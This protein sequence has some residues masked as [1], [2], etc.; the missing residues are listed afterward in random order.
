MLE[1]RL[2][3]EWRSGAGLLDLVEMIFC[4]RVEVEVPPGYCANGDRA[5]TRHQHYRQV[6]HSVVLGFFLPGW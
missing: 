4:L 2:R 1:T 5:S 6:D 3:H